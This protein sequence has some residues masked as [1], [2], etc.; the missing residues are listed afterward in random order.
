MGVA[1]SRFTRLTPGKSVDLWVALTQG[2]QLGLGWA[3]GADANNWWLVVVGRLQSGISQ[4]QAQAAVNALFVNDALHGAKP[5]WT[6]ADDP[7][8]W[9]LPAQQG[10]TGIRSEYGKPLMLLM[11]AVGIVLLIACANIAGLMLARSA[12]REPEM[13]VRLAVGAARQR[14]IRQLLTESLLLSFLGAALGA[15]L[16]YAGAAGLEAFFSK[17]A[18]LPLRLDLEPNALVLLFTIGVDANRNRLW[19]CAGASWTRQ[20]GDGTE[21]KH[22]VGNRTQSWTSSGPGKMARSHAGGALDGGACRCGPPAANAQ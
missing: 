13:A 15:L 20:P 4:E 3:Q 7:H 5:V 2:T 18:S 19:A 12:A 11:A 1:D 9:L 17:N 16:A 22:G 10:L 6:A 14:L 8:L 21:E